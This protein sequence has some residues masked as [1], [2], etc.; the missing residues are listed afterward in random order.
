[1]T[2]TDT[3]AL[4]LAA[5][6]GEP[7]A[8]LLEAKVL[9]ELASARWAETPA[10]QEPSE[11]VVAKLRR[12][13]FIAHWSPMGLLDIEEDPDVERRALLLE[14]VRHGLDAQMT[15]AGPRLIRCKAHGDL[16]VASWALEVDVA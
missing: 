5:Q 14:H 6:R 15:L 13:R 1:M 2:D 3:D 16:W 8:D 12:L 11:E 7:I 10:A 4:I 9:A